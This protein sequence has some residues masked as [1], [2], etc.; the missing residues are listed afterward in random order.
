MKPSKRE[1]GSRPRRNMPLAACGISLNATRD[2]PK[3]IGVELRR[4]PSLAAAKWLSS[5]GTN[6]VA[7]RVARADCEDF[8]HRALAD[9]DVGAVASFDARPTSGAAR[10]RTGSRRSLRTAASAFSFSWSRHAQHRDVEQVLQPG[11][12]EAVQVGVF[13]ERGPSPRR[14]RRDGARE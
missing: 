5:S 3:A 2:D 10:N 12:V 9:Q 4:A 11:L 14:G 8:L 6:L 7:D 1:I 13:A